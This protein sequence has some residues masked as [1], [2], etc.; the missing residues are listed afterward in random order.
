MTNYQL[1][2]TQRIVLSKKEYN[3]LSKMLDEKHNIVL[4]QDVNGAKHLID[5]KYVV[6]TK[7]TKENNKP[8]SLPE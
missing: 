4:V 6:D 1:D 2:Y 3:R 8:E 7:V 5:W